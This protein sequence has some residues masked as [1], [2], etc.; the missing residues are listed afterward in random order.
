MASVYGNALKLLFTS[1]Q[2]TVGTYARDDA[3]RP[4]E[5]AAKNAVAW[6]IYGALLTEG[7]DG[8]RDEKLHAKAREFIAAQPEKPAVSQYDDP[9]LVIN[10][11]P[12][13]G[14]NA[15]VHLLYEM[16]KASGAA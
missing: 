16:D 12:M 1:R 7:H 8:Y 10:D 9:V 13:F 6:N 2:F 15:V 4:C 3:G 5:P 11:S 14:H